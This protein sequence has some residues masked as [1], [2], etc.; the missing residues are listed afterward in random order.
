MP[1]HYV[2]VKYAC[3]NK[4]LDMSLSHGLHSEFHYVNILE[5]LTIPSFIRSGIKITKKM[6]NDCEG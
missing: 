1:C 2:K 6:L 4:A 3:L 5:L